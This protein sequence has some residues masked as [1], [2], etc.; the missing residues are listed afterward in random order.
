MHAPATTSLHP[1][2]PLSAEEISRAVETLRAEGHVSEH[3]RFV[4]VMLHEPDRKAGS[5]TPREAFCILLDRASGKTFEAV[6]NLETGQVSYSKYIPDVQPAITLDEFFEC[7]EM[8]RNHP[9]YQTAV[10]RR[11][12]S[13][14]GLLM[15]D[16]W[17]AG[18]YHSDNPA[19]GGRRL[20]RALSWV[21]SEAGENGYARPL[22]GLRALVDL[23]T[24]ELIEL[25]DTGNVPIPEQAGNYAPQ[26][27]ES[28]QSAPAPLEIS[29]PEGPGFRV[30]GHLIEWEGWSVRIGFT[31]REGL[32]LH[33]LKCEGRPVIAR[34]A[35]V[36]MIVPYGDPHEGHARKNA[37]DCGEYGI[38]M[39]ANS[40]ALGCDCLGVIRY[41]DAHLVNSRGEPVTIKNAVCLHEEDYGLLWKHMDWRTGQTEIRRSRRLVISFIATVGN[42]EYG[43]FW[44]LYLD[45][46]I[47]H[48]VK[49]TGIMNTGALPPGEKR[50]YGTLV[51]PGLYAP[52]HQHVFSYRLDMAVDGPLNS[53]QEINTYAEPEGPEN[54]YGNGFYAQPSTLGTETARD[55]DLS[56]ARYWKVI[57][58][59]LQNTLGEAPGYKILFGENA[60]PFVRPESAVRRRAGYMDH[61]LWITPYNHEEKY[62]VGDYPNQRSPEVR[63]G[64]PAWIEKGRSIENTEIVCWLTVTS[65]HVPRPE[66]WP[67]MPCGYIGFHLKPV[68]FFDRNPAINLPAAPS[69]HSIEVKDSG[70]GCCGNG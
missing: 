30:D 60:F 68:G 40:L 45:G 26:F 4:A 20:V 9:D 16:P 33:E 46:T 1:L 67:V 19:H 12:I 29:Q 37:F 63:D 18:A 52:I 57:N 70:G 28:M 5:A 41:F 48:E 50:K 32:V 47:Q 62:A 54:P 51:A 58:P 55:L 31:P 34:A 23:N 44:Y 27:Q 22:E 11:G 53:V 7:E 64:L 15:I 2:T 21:R 35:L 8:L 13:D 61:H 66:D 59:N 24:L 38:G 36:D 43:F 69:K 65:H 14:F 56:T 39:L 6:V 25:E 10:K 17:S 42:Y 49:L 3:T